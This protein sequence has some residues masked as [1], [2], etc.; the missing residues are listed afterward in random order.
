MQH[1]GELS[2]GSSRHLCGYADLARRAERAPGS[3]GEFHL[4]G[5]PSPDEVCSGSETTED[6][7]DRLSRLAVLMVE[8]GRG[9]AGVSATRNL[10]AGYTYLAQ[11]VGH[12]VV[13]HT[14]PLATFDIAAPDLS[15]ERRIEP[16]VLETIYGG[17]PVASPHVYAVPPGRGAPRRR[18]RLG[19]I[20]GAP[21]VYPAEPQR[22][23]PRVACPHLNDALSDGRR[24]VLIGDPRNDDNLI[25]S[26]LTVVFHLLHNM[27]VDHLATT[28]EDSIVA[29]LQA[30]RH[31]T[32][33]LGRRVVA[34]IWRDIVVSDLL[35]RLLDERVCN[36]YS[37]LQ[38]AGKS[39]AQ[40]DDGGKSGDVPL[41][42]SFAAFRFGHAMIRRSYDLNARRGRTGLSDVLAHTS[43]GRARDMPLSADWLVQWSRFF[44]LGPGEP[45]FSR[46]LGPSI[47]G[48]LSRTVEPDR[49]ARGGLAF[50]DL[51][52]G[53]AARLRSVASLVKEFRARAPDNI[54]P[55]HPLYGDQEARSAFVKLWL[56][57]RAPVVPPSEPRLGDAHIAALAQDPPLLF[58]VLL[59]AE[60][61]ARG[62]RLGPLGSLIVAESLYPLLERKRALIEDDPVV[63]E[64]AGYVF[65]S[66][67][68]RT[69]AAL[70]TDLGERLDLARPEAGFI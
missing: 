22:D 2:V 39:L 19:K 45:E 37:T 42:F 7:E 27:V 29:H 47:V 11:L 55:D 65:A 68:P 52:S 49:L 38:G 35:Q 63:Q 58:F 6:M 59:E 60:V 43:D 44:D 56:E 61:I 14:T 4:F 1:H 23:I 24:D 62:D 8:L 46:K 67:R 41:E 9:D 57:K 10:P 36:F 50:E 70:L 13:H 48:P 34:L 31:Q 5:P 16:L 18:L 54:F 20:Q 40:R 53:A 32:F 3:L 51:R 69:M 30:D 66:G 25:L 64:V 26:Q 28:E 12:D 15:G 21:L 33:L 17:G